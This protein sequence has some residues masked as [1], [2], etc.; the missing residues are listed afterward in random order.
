MMNKAQEHDNRLD[1]IEGKLARMERTLAELGERIARL[2]KASRSSK[3]AAKGFGSIG[4]QMVTSK[5]K[6]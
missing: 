2:E 4:V 1:E 3:N 6:R 5:S